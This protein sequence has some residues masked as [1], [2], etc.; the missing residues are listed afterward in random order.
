MRCVVGNVERVEKMQERDA[1][2]CYELVTVRTKVKQGCG[3]K[4]MQEMRTGR[5]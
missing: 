3:A 1:L 2:R 4:N 5:T